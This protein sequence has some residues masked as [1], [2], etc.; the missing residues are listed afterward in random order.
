MLVL[1]VSVSHHST[2]S[3]AQVNWGELYNPQPLEEASLL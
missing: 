1:V 3:V 2:V